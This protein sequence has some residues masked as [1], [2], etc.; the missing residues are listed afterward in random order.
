MPDRQNTM[1]HFECATARRMA[2]HRRLDQSRDDSVEKE[3]Q[4]Q[5]SD[6][7]RQPNERSGL[8][9]QFLRRSPFKLSDDA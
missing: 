9:V 8:T 6:G 3:Y 4:R 5:N 1:N 2:E 7:S